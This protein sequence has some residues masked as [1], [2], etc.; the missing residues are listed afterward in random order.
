METKGTRIPIENIRANVRVPFSFN[1][2]R[3]ATMLIIAFLI[4]A[5]LPRSWLW[6]TALDTHNRTQR[7]VFIA[8]WIPLMIAVAW[9]II[10]KIRTATPVVFH[11]PGGYTYDFDQYGHIADSLLQGNL[12]LDL[13][14]SPALAHTAD[15]YDIAQRNQLLAQGTSPIYWDYAFYQGHWYS[16]FGVIPALLL[17]APFRVISSWFIP[18]GMMLPAACAELFL[19]LGAC[20]T[21]CLL[22]IRLLQR[23]QHHY[24]LAIVAMSCIAYMLGANMPY[25]WFRTNFYS[26]PFAASLLLAQWGLWLWLGALRDDGSLRWTH[27]A[28]G[29]LCIAATFGCRPTFALTALFAFPLFTPTLITWWRAHRTR[30]IITFLLALILPALLVVIPLVIY[31]WLRFGAVLDF[32]NAYQITVANMTTFHTPLQNMPQTLGYYL[33][34]PLHLSS[35]FPFIEISATPLPHWSF[36][37]PC[38]GGLCAMMPLTILAAATP[39]LRT[40]LGRVWSLCITADVLAIVL[41]VFD[42]LVG[43]FGWRYMAD[44]GWLFMIAAIPVAAYLMHRFPGTRGLITIIVF[45]SLLI[46]LLSCFTLGREDMLIRNDPAL[47]HTVRAWFTLL[48]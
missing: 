19:M 10:W 37:E 20:I 4:I 44:F 35:T 36:T 38:I 32:G 40:R 45:V 42:A 28:G 6:R 25:L 7:L 47:Y 16:Y 18:G 22:I 1:W 17:F 39:W 27:V 29:A 30:S 46:A 8:V 13:P 23:T 2:A 31:N 5:F 11:T 21:G 43:G 12:Y 41:L 33:F 26:I 15:P 48:S 9:Q 24:S 34:L 14:V 3:V